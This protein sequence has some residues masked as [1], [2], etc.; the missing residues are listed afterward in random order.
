[1]THLTTLR[2]SATT[3]IRQLGLLTDD[4]LIA[5]GLTV[6]DFADND[7]VGENPPEGRKF[8]AVIQLF[9]NVV[10]SAY[11]FLLDNADEATLAEQLLNL[12]LGD[13]KLSNQEQA[14]ILS[15][16]A[17]KKFVAWAAGGDAKTF[18]TREI[19]ETVVARV[20]RDSDRERFVDGAKENLQ[21]LEDALRTAI[22]EVG[23]QPR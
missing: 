5:E 7:L 22:L 20:L 9:V 1:M 18:D 15:L 14:L 11:S 8:V 19:E 2:K 10:S 3:A 6:E 23:D 16:V 4:D 21:L 12:D 13:T 17:L